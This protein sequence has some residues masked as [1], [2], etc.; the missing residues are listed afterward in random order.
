LA[1]PEKVMADAAKPARSPRSI[2]AAED[3]SSAQPAARKDRSTAPFGLA[4]AA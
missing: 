2:S 4:L 3:T 1:G